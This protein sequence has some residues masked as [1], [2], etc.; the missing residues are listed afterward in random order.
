MTKFSIIAR[1]DTAVSHKLKQL[2]LIFVLCSPS[3]A[4]LH[5]AKHASLEGKFVR[6]TV[7]LDQSDHIK[8]V[9]CDMD[10]IQVRF[11]NSSA[12]QVAESSWRGDDG[13]NL[14]TYHV[15]CGD[16][17]SG[18]RSFFHVSHTS[19][20]IH[21]LCAVMTVTEI[22]EEEA[23]ESAVLS[24]GTYTDPSN[25]KRSPAKGHVRVERPKNS[26]HRLPGRPMRTMN[27]TVITS[28]VTE[29]PVINGTV[30]ITT[31]PK[32]FHYF[33]NNS[34]LNTTDMGAKIPTM[35][36]LDIDDYE[37]PDA[38]NVSRRS[39]LR[40]RHE[41]HRRIHTELAARSTSALARRDF[42]GDIWEGLKALGRVS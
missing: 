15:G 33:F 10:D 32:A 22:Q 31:N 7:V 27:G 19:F 39:S 8:S 20:N 6:G 12:L 24:W 4:A 30:D 9:T 14:A 40:S 3:L 13:F 18:K 35:P 17:A 25:R 23:L 1:K 34:Q 16:E 42:F 5:G 26:N 36:F 29:P 38:K 41:R 37:T 2:G 21:T 28:N 11:K